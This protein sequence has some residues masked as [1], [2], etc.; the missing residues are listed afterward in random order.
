MESSYYLPDHLLANIAL[1]LANKPNALS[2]VNLSITCPYW[3]SICKPIIN[4]IST[5]NNREWFDILGQQHRDNDQPAVISANGD[6]EWYQHSQRHRDNDQPAIIY[7]YG[8][9]AW[10]QHGKY[11][12]DNNQPAVIRANGTQIWYQHDKLHCDNGRAAII[13]A[14]GTQEWWVNGHNL[15][16]IWAILSFILILHLRRNTVAS[17]LVSIIFEQVYSLILL[18]LR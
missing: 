17:P 13:Y 15:T 5:P 1:Y 3:Y 6:R 9:Q 10:F 7:A 12:R 8:T 2:I 11:H 16:T 18:I 4:Q 14:N